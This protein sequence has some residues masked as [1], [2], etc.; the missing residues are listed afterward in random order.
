M[1]HA[2]VCLLTYYLPLAHCLGSFLIAFDDGEIRSYTPEMLMERIK[3]KILVEACA[4][5][6]GVVA[7]ETGHGKAER[8]T[9]YSTG[10]RGAKKVAGVLIGA[11][12]HMLGA[13]VI[14]ETHMIRPNAFDK[15]PPPARAGAAAAA[16]AAIA[17]SP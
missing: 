17:I 12:G 15:S 9:Y 16:A 1:T 14:Y 5:D 3:S 4:E 10:G 2:F 13:D 8:L 7:S 11:S 6:G